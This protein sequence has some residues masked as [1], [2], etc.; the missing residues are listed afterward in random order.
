[1]PVVKYDM[2]G[3]D[4]A[5]ARQSDYVQPPPGTHRCK[6]LSCDP[7]RS[8]ENKTPMLVVV[9]RPTKGNFGQVWYYV[10][11]SDKEFPKR[12]M[13]QFLQAVGVTSD[14]K[15]TGSFNT[16]TIVGKEV[17]VNFRARRPD[18]G[19]PPGTENDYRAE[20]TDVW[21]PGVLDDEDEF[22]ATAGGG[23]DEAFDSEAFE[24]EET[25]DDTPDEEDDGLLT[26]D[27]IV[28]MEAPELKAILK[29]YEV[30]VPPRVRAPKLRE[31]VL[32]A[33]AAY[34]EENGLENPAAG[35]TEPEEDEEEEAFE[36]D[37]G[38][39]EETSDSEYLTE[40]QLKAMPMEELGKTAG[41]FDIVPK[42]MKR[43]E[44]VKAILEA[45]AAD[46]EEPF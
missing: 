9:F 24:D 14:Q 32:E 19:T 6:I 12:K 44:V 2:S 4:P 10:T 30:K 8:K 11:F 15:R 25:M 35:A 16:D 40:A 18:K 5:E 38:E 37:E 27:V 46:D 29:E 20:V 31:M 28:A 42:G 23:E 7:D 3:V 13:D 43:S 34:C 36:D 17:M 22:D 26:E 21:A 1:M 45:Q 41:E 33:Q 39:V